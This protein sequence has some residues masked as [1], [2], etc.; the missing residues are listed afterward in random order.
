MSPGQQEFISDPHNQTFRYRPADEA[1]AE[2]TVDGTYD[3][4]DGRLRITSL[5]IRPR[6]DSMPPRGISGEL[7]RRIHP[8]HFTDRL[9]S[10]ERTYAQWL[11]DNLAE[12]DPDVA[13]RYPDSVRAIQKLIEQARRMAEPPRSATTELRGAPRLD[14]AFLAHI[15]LM[16]RQQIDDDGTYGS[17]KRLAEE[18]GKPYNTV[19]DWI[20]KAK[21]RGLYPP[22]DPVTEHEE[23]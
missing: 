8:A 21:R 19:K 12:T 22:E 4:T 23:E 9:K 3:V 17:T 18:L 2:W 1:L 7:L 10:T 11:D 16:H 5:T 15:A 14:S 13:N 6:D 20:A